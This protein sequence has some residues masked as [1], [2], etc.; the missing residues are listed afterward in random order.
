MSIHSDNGVHRYNTRVEPEWLDYNGHMNVAYY[1]LAFDRAGEQFVASVGLSEAHTVETGNSW[2]VTEAH[3]TYQNEAMSGD[4]LEVTSRILALDAK[5]IH[6]FQSMFR[7][8][9]ANLLATNEQLVLH[10]NLKLRKVCPFAP[11]VLEKL[12]RL[13]MLHQRLTPPPEAGRSIGI[14][15]RRP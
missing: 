1:T 12:Q 7:K 10:V 11:Q 4:E 5:R 13:S 3:I 14:D 2:M 8:G 6:L 9:D 15:S